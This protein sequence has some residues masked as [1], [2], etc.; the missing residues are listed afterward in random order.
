MDMVGEKNSDV[1]HDFSKD[2]IQ[3]EFQGEWLKAKGTTLG[4]DNG[5]GLAAA[6]SIIDSKDVVHGPLELLFTVDEEVGLTGAGKL[7]PGFVKGEHDDEPRQRGARRR[8]YR[9]LG[10]GRHDAQAPGRF[11]STL[12]PERRDSSSR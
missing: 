6:L 12:P 10:R 4:S 5:I 8:L 7:K 2:P 3:L 9:L 1:V 11:S